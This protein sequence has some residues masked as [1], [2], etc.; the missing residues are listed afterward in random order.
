DRVDLSARAKFL[1]QL[2]VA[3][4]VVQGVGVAGFT[5]VGPIAGLSFELGWTAVP[6]SILWIVGITNAV[7]LTDGVD[8][9][10]TSTSFFTALAVAMI[11]IVSRNV[12]VAVM[13]GGL[14]G[15]LAGFLPF[16][17]RPARLFLGD[18]GSQSV[19]MLLAILSMTA[20]EGTLGEGKL[21][22]PVLL[23]GY[24]ILDTMIV[25]ARRLLSGKSVFCGDLSHIHHRMLAKG[26]DHGQITL[27][28][29]ALAG[30]FCYAGV[31]NAV[32]NWTWSLVALA[33]LAAGLVVGALLLGYPSHLSVRQL[34]KNSGR[35]MLVRD[36]ARL[37][38]SELRVASN[39]EAAFETI[40]RLG[41][42]FAVHRIVLLFQTDGPIGQRLKH[43]ALAPSG[44]FR[45][46]RI[47]LEL[48]KPQ[49]P[50]A[51]PAD[52][53]DPAEEAAAPAAQNPQANGDRTGQVVR[54]TLHFPA[55]GLTIRYHVLQTEQLPE[56][57]LERRV[58]MARVFKALACCLRN[59]MDLA[60]KVKTPAARVDR[61]RGPQQ[62]RDRPPTHAPQNLG[63]Q[64]VAVQTADR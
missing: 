50:P 12:A 23:L 49:V 8:G 19:G 30:L 52:K 11:A 15:A 3:I 64:A 4:A 63:A 40:R 26:M 43:K 38:I 41:T 36:Q 2:A 45:R 5:Q 34:R 21:I 62:D 31:S 10:A 47:I 39:L 1:V 18:T 27:W 14:A 37:A 9:L 32:G 35:F 61:K 44:P 6:I 17:R 56:L 13:A 33:V 29:S 58:Q 55:Q 54:E 51:E 57:Q 7:N 59:G 46:R 20:P 25:I 22:V 16:N 60:A 28:L 42:A 24:P 53:A 48:P